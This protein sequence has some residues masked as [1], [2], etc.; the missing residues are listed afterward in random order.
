MKTKITI[1]TSVL[2]LLIACQINPSST[3]MNKNGLIHLKALHTN[4]MVDDVQLTVDFYAKIGF[5]ILQ[6][7]PENDAEWAYVKKDNVRLMFQS[8]KSLQSE[9]PELANR[10]P[11]AALTLWIQ[12]E[13]IEG[14]YDEIKDKVNVIRPLGVTTY[15][16]ATEFVIQDVNGV[17]LHFSNH[18]L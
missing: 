5:E 4:L 9:F 6:K 11:D 2:V 15:N 13:N 14:Y 17:V 18:E 10:K 8:T 1:V 12:T 7:L 3:T 16:K